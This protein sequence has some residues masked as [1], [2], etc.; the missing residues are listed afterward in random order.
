MHNYDGRGLPDGMEL[1]HDGHSHHVDGHTQAAV[2]SHHAKMTA[3]VGSSEEQY[4]GTSKDGHAEVSQH[5]GLEKGHK[6]TPRLLHGSQFGEGA[7]KS[8]RG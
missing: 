6:V 3:G 8:F 2:N 4:G 5:D 7:G 1:D